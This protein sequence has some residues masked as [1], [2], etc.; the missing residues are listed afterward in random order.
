MFGFTEHC[1]TSFKDLKNIS[2]VQ[3]C[4]MTVIKTNSIE[5]FGRQ[6]DVL[7]HVRPQERTVFWL[8]AVPLN[9]VLSTLF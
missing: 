1:I 6:L 3:R 9:K 4:R 2:H 5:H 8:V 7:S